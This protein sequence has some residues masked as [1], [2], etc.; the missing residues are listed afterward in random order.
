M[1]VF[2]TIAQIEINFGLK[3]NVEKKIILKKHTTVYLI[4]AWQLNG[5]GLSLV[6]LDNLLSIIN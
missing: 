5:G 6:P 1:N 2:R 4:D 3:Y